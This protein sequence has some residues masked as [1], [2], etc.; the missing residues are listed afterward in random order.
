MDKNLAIEFSSLIMVDKP[1]PK[2]HEGW[3][4][5]SLSKYKDTNEYFVDKTIEDNKDIIIVGKYKDKITTFLKE[6]LF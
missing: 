6:S 3:P 1:S 5:D 4:L 2:R